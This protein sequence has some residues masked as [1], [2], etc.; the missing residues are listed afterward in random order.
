MSERPSAGRPAERG[1]AK[2]ERGPERPDGEQRERERDAS[3]ERVPPRPRRR[4]DSPLRRQQAA[5]TR[6]R[7]VA[8]G[9]EILH[10][11]PVWNWRELTVRA[12]AQR[13]G[14]NERTVYRHFATERDLRDAVL[15]R[16]EEE[17][18]VDLEGLA[19]DDVQDLT[20]RIF[21]HVSAFPLEPRTPRDPTI[22]AASQ[23]QREALLAAVAP[24]T[25]DWP[26]DDR[27]LAAAMLDVLW[28]VVAYERVVA[29]W[30][31][32]PKEAI[33]GLTWVMGLVQ[34]AV[35]QGRRPGPEGSRATE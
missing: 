12:V 32:D 10:E 2:N 14:V 4:Y 29:D 33:R 5:E 13:A 31:L 21:R 19:F 28:S 34:D 20:A 25:G 3:S 15:V 1:P 17:A 7:I 30:E 27:V 8:A 22:M 11:H 16:L 9:A 35:R 23:R 6:A 24:L 26:E 18:D